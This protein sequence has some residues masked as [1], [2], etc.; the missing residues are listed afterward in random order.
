VKVEK[1]PPPQAESTYNLIGLTARQV[2]VIM[3]AL[4]A[5]GSLN[6]SNGHM[7]L[8]KEQLDIRGD[9]AESK[10]CADAGQSI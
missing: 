5:I 4:F 1:I 8:A 7:P 2:Q 9:I 10:R 3:D 6:H